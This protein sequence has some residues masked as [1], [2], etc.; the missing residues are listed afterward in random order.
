MAR[1]IDQKAAALA[2]AKG[3]QTVFAAL[4]DHDKPVTGAAAKKPARAATSTKPQRAAAPAKPP[5]AAAPKAQPT[6]TTS[7][8]TETK[9]MDTE[10][11]TPT[12]DANV[13]AE[14][15]RGLMD[16]KAVME[17]TQRLAQEASELAKGNLEAMMASSKIAAQNAGTLG[18]DVAELGRKSFEGASEAMKSFAEA[19]SP[20]ELLRL[21]SEFAK[22]YMETMFAEGAR[23]SE[24]MVKLTGEALQPVQSRVA[25]NVEKA[26]S[27][28]N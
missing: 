26:K 5:R 11:L 23:L 27:I 12:L 4:D 18:Q 2:A 28:S 24:T 25:A 10:T 1:K 8:K 22:S 15:M 17:R 19:K 7:A 9:T 3:S 6:D 13:V 20:T 14:R 16:G 21:Q